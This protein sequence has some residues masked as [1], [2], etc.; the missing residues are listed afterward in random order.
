MKQIQSFRIL[1]L[2]L[3]FT[4]SNS[5]AQSWSAYNSPNGQF[6]FELPGAPLVIDSLNVLFYSYDQDSIIGLQVHYIENVE[7]DPEQAYLTQFIGENNGGILDI[8]VKTML[9]FT[10]GKIISL[11][12]IIPVGTTIQ[13]IEVGVEYLENTDEE[14]ISFMR[15]Y[16][17]DKK[18]LTLNGT[19]T[20]KDILQLYLFKERFFNS[21]IIH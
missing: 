13:G 16:Y 19:A 14:Y 4:S 21:L 17:W 20:K 7:L 6:S 1:L 12:K 18:F 9:Y 2:L 8:F 10:G 3:I 5:K 15:F 11:Q